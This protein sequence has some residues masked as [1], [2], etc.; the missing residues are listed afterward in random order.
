MLV[1]I[2]MIVTNKVIAQDTTING[3]QYPKPANFT[4]QQNQE[5]MMQQLG[6][7]ELRPGQ[8]EIHQRQIMQTM[9]PQNQILAR[10]CRIF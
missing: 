9:I 5:N 3:K 4:S 6:I 10:N 7:K 8:A 2:V 1:L